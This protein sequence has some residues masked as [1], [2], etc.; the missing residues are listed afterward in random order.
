MV[1]TVIGAFTS[2]A[3]LNARA[4]ERLILDPPAPAA[5]SASDILTPGSPADD[6][7]Q[8][9]RDLEAQKADVN[10]KARPGVSLDVN[11]SVSGQVQSFKR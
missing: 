5:N 11:G 2:G 1:A 9:V 8:R 4:G 10:R 3:G 7:D 6:L